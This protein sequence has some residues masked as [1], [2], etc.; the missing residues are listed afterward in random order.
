MSLSLAPEVS[1]T[2]DAGP[3]A[4]SPRRRRSQLSNADGEAAALEEGCVPSAGASPPA[5]A[6][7]GVRQPKW[8]LCFRMD[9]KDTRAAS[10]VAWKH[11]RDFFVT[12]VDPPAEVLRKLQQMESPQSQAQP[13]APGKALEPPAPFF[14]SEVACQV[15]NLLVGRPFLEQLPGQSFERKAVAAV[16]ADCLTAGLVAAMLGARVAFVTE[17]QFLQVVK[18]NVQLY[19]KDTLDYTKT[20]SS[21]VAVAC[22]ERPGSLSCEHL[23]EQMSAA[24]PLDV[25][26]ITETS[27]EKCGSIHGSLG[28]NRTKQTPTKDRIGQP[29]PPVAK[30]EI[31]DSSTSKLFEVLNELVPAQAPAKVLL[32]CDGR[33]SFSEE[34][35]ESSS[36]DDNDQNEHPVLPPAR[37]QPLPIEAELPMTW[38]ARPFCTL[39][40]R[41]PVVWLERVDAD[42]FRF[43]ANRKPLAPFRRYLPPMGA[44]S[45]KCGCGGH[46]QRNFLNHKVMNFDWR[47][48]HSRLKEALVLHNRWKCIENAK[49]LEKAR[50]FATAPLFVSTSDI[51][52][53]AGSRT[54]PGTAGDAF[55]QEH[56]FSE[57]VAS[58]TSP[59]DSANQFT[60]PRALGSLKECLHT[61]GVAFTEGDEVPVSLARPPVR[62]SAAD[63]ACSHSTFAAYRKQREDMIRRSVMQEQPGVNLGG[64]ASNSVATTLAAVL[65]PGLTAA[66]PSDSHGEALEMGHSEFDLEVAAETMRVPADNCEVP[67]VDAALPQ[68]RPP[69]G[70]SPRTPRRRQGIGALAGETMKGSTI[71]ERHSQPPHWYRCNRVPYG[72][73]R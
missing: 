19:L 52:S 11:Q 12:V 39:L 36:Q 57:T 3:K 48:S 6:P 47:E 59:D 66:S 16:G 21:N 24:P 35:L 71:A 15:A 22:A 53:Q 30:E 4:L 13:P 38:H 18:Q 63:A 51:A 8:R 28:G 5:T 50:A 29:K 67:A 9:R 41:F 68:L 34:H 54:L 56:G 14:A 31:P 10:E 46:P 2:E 37:G 25:V 20:K 62:A 61:M 23:C 17:R 65:E 26:V 69:M 1:D 72:L 42:P 32:V 55:G 73:P 45:A 33:F 7:K 43:S 27:A 64:E 49:E 58:N 40:R 60:G 44:P 70:T